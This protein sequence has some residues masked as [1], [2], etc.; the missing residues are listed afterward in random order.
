MSDNREP[1]NLLGLQQYGKSLSAKLRN[2][3]KARGT[4]PDYIRKQ[5]VFTLFFNR[6]FATESAGWLLL[7]GNALL[8]RIG[9]GRF[10]RDIDLARDTPWDD[11]DAVL[12]ELQTLVGSKAPNDP[13]TFDLH[14]I[15]PNRA[16]D[17][18]GYGTTTATVSVKIYLGT[19][20]F[21]SFSIDLTSRRHVDG[22]VDQVRPRP[23]ID[24]HTLED[25]CT[26]PVVPIENHL[27]DKL[28]AMYE[29]HSSGPSTRYR[30]L[31]DIVRIIQQLSFDAERLATVFAHEAQR[32]KMTAPNHVT[33]PDAAWK[34]AYPKA[35][36]TF[37]EYPKE[38]W[39]LDASLKVAA[40]CLDGVLSGAIQHGRWD[41][42]LQSWSK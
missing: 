18:Y 37:A 38:L 14:K 15:T 26:V 40:A 8:V 21:E 1:L 17:A 19:H 4:A 20:E 25:L 35:A 6:L 24:H 9:G 22:P 7:G 36:E 31:A 12:V 41:P 23:I 27:A 33:A 34:S 11:L 2:E 42:E 32:R 16:A 10:T 13:F 28:C 39:P 3:A 30:D 5:Y 29:V